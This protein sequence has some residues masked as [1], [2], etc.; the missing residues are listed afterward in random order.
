MKR[1]DD[2]SRL[3]SLL[4]Q[5][6]E[7][8]ERQDDFDPMMDAANSYF[9]AGSRCMARDIPRYMYEDPS[10]QRHIERLERILSS[11]D[12]KTDKIRRLADASYA[13]LILDRTGSPQRSRPNENL[14]VSFH[15]PG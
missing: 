1:Q 5:A 7:T 3:L 8:S 12:D 10:L 9:L 4:D 11:S 6:Y 13:Q 2:C 14:N 15:P